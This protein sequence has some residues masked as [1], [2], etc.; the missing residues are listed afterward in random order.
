MLPAETTIQQDAN[1][2]ILQLPIKRTIGGGNSGTVSYT[3]QQ[4][5]FSD[6]P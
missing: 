3:L 2:N 5:K 1:G 4:P 6:R